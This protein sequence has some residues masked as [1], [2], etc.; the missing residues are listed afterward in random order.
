MGE[1]WAGGVLEPLMPN[2]IEISIVEKE[3]ST[4][5]LISTTLQLC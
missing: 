3:T 5:T 1:E 4:T 2:V